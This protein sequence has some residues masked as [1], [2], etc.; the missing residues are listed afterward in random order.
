MA[1]SLVW[2]WRSSTGDRGPV[3]LDA[4]VR[5]VRVDGEMN[6]FTILI[7]VFLFQ[8]GIITALVMMSCGTAV[9][10]EWTAKRIKSRR[11]AGRSPTLKR[12]TLCGHELL[13]HCRIAS[14]VDVHSA[15]LGF[16]LN[17]SHN[18]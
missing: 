10:T 14:V 5:L 15:V 4:I 13:C 1:S 2:Y 11:R 6:R 8:L 12:S 3:D 17:A 7:V 16:R 18:I 9:F